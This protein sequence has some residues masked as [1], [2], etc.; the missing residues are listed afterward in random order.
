MWLSVPSWAFVSRRGN[1]STTKTI[2]ELIFF[3]QNSTWLML[4]A[5]CLHLMNAVLRVTRNSVIDVKKMKEIMQTQVRWPVPQESGA[6]FTLPNILIFNVYTDV[7]RKSEVIFSP[8]PLFILFSGQDNAN[9][10]DFLFTKS[11]TNF[12]KLKLS[13][14]SIELVDLISLLLFLCKSV[15]SCCEH[16]SLITHILEVPWTEG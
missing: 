1:K 9:E 2:K 15:S 14:D 16:N 5:A 6:M 7:E 13:P 10:K 3:V 4:W 8:L 12:M 11:R